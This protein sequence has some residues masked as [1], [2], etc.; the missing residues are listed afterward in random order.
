M[1]VKRALAER[2]GYRCS[3][4]E[5]DASTAGPSEEGDLKSS[6]TGVAAHISGASSGPGSRR[7]D[8]NISKAARMSIANGLWCCQL[9]GKLID[10]DE[11]T[12]STAMLQTWRKIAEKQ[13]KLRQA[14]GDIDFSNHAEL[15][16]IGMAE[17]AISVDSAEYPNALIGN[18][19]KYACVSQIWGKPSADAIRD[20]LVEHVR[21]S[22][23][24]GG[25]TSVGIEFRRKGLVI[26][27]DGQAFDEQ[28]LAQPKFG[29][30][31]GIAYR[32]LLRAL[33]ICAVS[34]LPDSGGG[35]ELYIP[36]VSGVSDLLE[37]NPCAVAVSREDMRLGKLEF[38]KLAGCNRAYVIAPQFMSFSDG[39]WCKEVIQFA[40][41]QQ[42]NTVLVLRDA[43]D[44]VVE[45]YK[46]FL[47]GIEII[48]W[49]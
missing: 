33:R 22:F 37:V 17:D 38:T 30:G 24:H 25:A 10:T 29:R 2:A 32:N 7:Y 15:I 12:Y 45:Q 49:A 19:V 42:E 43:S 4:P 48:S 9:H 1:P 20:Y 18:A 23:E 27:S 5:C 46:S 8:P 44:A 6:N 28:R 47:P 11:Q 36:L 41:E 35:Y 26:R 39:P 34:S 31:G 14:H 16:E 21:N 13:A 3:Y 40:I